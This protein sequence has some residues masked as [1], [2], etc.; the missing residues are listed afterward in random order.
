MTLKFPSYCWT[1]YLL[2]KILTD[3]DSPFSSLYHARCHDYPI[4]RPLFRPCGS[5]RINTEEIG[6]ELFLVLM[7]LLTVRH[8]LCEPNALGERRGTV[9]DSPM[10]VGLS[11]VSHVMKFV[12]W[13][14]SSR[15]FFGDWRFFVRLSITS[16]C[17]FFF[18]FI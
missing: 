4:Q 13:T 10:I 15:L 8:S 14:V 7:T 12:R 18:L 17:R 1:V 5:K 2:R 16:L 3:G 6:K 9:L 11:S